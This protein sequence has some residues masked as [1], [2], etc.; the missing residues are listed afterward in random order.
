[1]KYYTSFWIAH[2]M[3]NEKK[4]QIIKILFLVSSSVRDLGEYFSL[5]VV[6]RIYDIFLHE[7]IYDRK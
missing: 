3:W 6:R 7:M 5:R 4:I 1:M 2:S